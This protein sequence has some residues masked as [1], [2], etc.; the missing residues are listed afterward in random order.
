M[1]DFMLSLSNKICMRLRDKRTGYRTGEE[2]GNANSI[3]HV[4]KKKVAEDVFA[5][6]VWSGLDVFSASNLYLADLAFCVLV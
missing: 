2:T 1:Y 5:T 6:L 3:I 4:E